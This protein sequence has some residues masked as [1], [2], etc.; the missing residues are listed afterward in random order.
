MTLT[1]GRDF[2]MAQVSEDRRGRATGPRRSWASARPF[3]LRSTPFNRDDYW[4]DRWTRAVLHYRRLA[5]ALDV[6]I[7]LIVIPSFVVPIIGTRIESAGLAAAGVVGFVCCV[8][9]TRG[10]DVKNLG[11]GPG[12]YQAVARAGI[13]AAGILMTTS[14]STKAEISR[15]LVFIGVPTLVLVCGLVRY[16]HRKQL[17]RSRAARGESMRRTLVV[18]EP[19]AV[20]QVVEDLQRRPR[21]GYRVSGICVPSLDDSEPLED[22]PVL[23]ALADVPQVVADHA[24]EVVVVAGACL[25]GDALRRLSWALDRAGAQLVVAPGLVE[26]NAPRL[27][28]R[29]VAGLSLL[30][31]EIGAPRRR[32]LV[33]AVMDRTAGAALLAIALPIILASALAVRLTSPGSPFYHQ[34][35]VGVDG[36]TFTMWKL[37]SMYIDAA[38]RKQALLSDNE[39]DGVLFKMHNDPRVTTVGRV[40]R[41]FSLDELPQLLNVVKGDMS[42]VGPRPPLSEEVAAYGDAVHRRLRVKPGLTGLWQVSGRSDLTWEESVRLDLRYVDNWSVAMDLLILWRTARAVVGASGAY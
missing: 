18:G 7:A 25:S 36:Q 19:G 3:E 4:E 26:V 42:L 24:V 35:R 12:E 13:L 11:D 38:A 27:S 1:A 16:I 20:A 22:A 30:E 28:L 9:L 41:R 32:L 29:P 21:E 14:Y 34:T 23:G 8:A 15:T 33:K 2:D 6:L 31:V 10:Y 5:L 39:S 17:H 40:L 37:R